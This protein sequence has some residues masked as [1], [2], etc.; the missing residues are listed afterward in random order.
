MVSV[1][2]YKFIQLYLHIYSFIY[3]FTQFYLLIYTV[4]LPNIS[5]IDSYIKTAGFPRRFGT[6]DLTEYK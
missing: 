1:F 5:I 2:V 3:K 6:P 4:L